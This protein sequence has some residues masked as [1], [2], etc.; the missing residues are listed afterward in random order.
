[1]RKKIKNNK[2]VLISIAIVVFLILL[3]LIVALA[4]RS[5]PAPKYNENSGYTFI[6][7]TVETPGS[8]V[9]TNDQIKAEHCLGD[10]CLTDV[11]VYYVNESGRLD[12]KITNKGNSKATG[13]LKI[14]LGFTSLIIAY[15]NLE[16]G[17]TADT[18]ASFYNVK[19]KQ[20]ADYSL[21]E[22]SKE[23]KSK[24]VEGK[25]K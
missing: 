20:F 25:K 14:N 16:A 17:G 18:S 2:M 10:I 7:S 15:K 4:V 19:F 12:C 21:S 11:K 1:M 23:D 9:Y 24:I 5:H 13:Y 3:V 22:L 8:E 6:D